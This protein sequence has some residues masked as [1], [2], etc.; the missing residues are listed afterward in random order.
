MRPRKLRTILA[1]VLLLAVTA[2]VLVWSYN[3][4]YDQFRKKNFELR[5]TT[6]YSEGNPLEEINFDLFEKFMPNMAPAGFSPEAVKLRLPCDVR[7]YTHQ[8]DAEP[9][10][11]L[12]KGT[13]VYAVS[14]REGIGHIRAGYGTAS[15]PSYEKGWRYAQPFQVTAE[16]ENDA[17]YFVR[18]SELEKVA[19]AFLRMIRENRDSFGKYMEMLELPENIWAQTRYTDMALYDRGVFCSEDLERMFLW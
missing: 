14:V 8:E 9:A 10:L 6:G 19:G 12:K 17:M 2:A 7:Y 1:A 18:L 16:A 4:L 11:T 5:R 3:G 15:W 13:E